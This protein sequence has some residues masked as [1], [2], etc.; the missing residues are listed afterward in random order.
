MPVTLHT[1]VTLEVSLALYWYWGGGKMTCGMTVEFNHQITKLYN[2]PVV[3]PW[4]KTLAV[5]ETD[6]TTLVAVQV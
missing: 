1:N 5:A 6:P 2:G 4:T 3:L